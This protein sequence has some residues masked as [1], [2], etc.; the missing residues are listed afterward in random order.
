MQN[1]TANTMQTPECQC[2]SFTGGV[3]YGAGFAIG[4]SL[5][6]LTFAGLYTLI[7]KR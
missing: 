2:P 7:K 1:Y 5:V 4:V 3:Q 6:G